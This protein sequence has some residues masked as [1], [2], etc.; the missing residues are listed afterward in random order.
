MLC[1]KIFRLSTERKIKES[2]RPKKNTDN[3][4]NLIIREKLAYVPIWSSFFKGNIL[5][6]PCSS[7][8]CQHYLRYW[9]ELSKSL[10]IICGLYPHLASWQEARKAIHSSN[11]LLVSSW[12]K[13]EKIGRKKKHETKCFFLPSNLYR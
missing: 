7:W 8:W 2:K 13:R 5:A 3:T 10:F 12:E 4:S 11:L 9:L 6:N 1:L